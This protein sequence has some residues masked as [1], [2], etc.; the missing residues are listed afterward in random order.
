M[1]ASSV[2]HYFLYPS[3]KDPSM[4][5]PWLRRNP[6]RKQI[7]RKIRL[8]IESLEDRITP[9]ALLPDLHVLVSYMPGGGT[10]VANMTATSNGSGGQQISFS[11]AMA[12]GGQGA[13]ELRGQ[14]V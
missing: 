9:T 13:F 7:T 11:T 3:R 1:N 4:I 5:T 2:C 10:S 12:N 6:S 8:W 14:P